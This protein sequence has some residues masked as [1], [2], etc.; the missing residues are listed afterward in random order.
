MLTG[1][2]SRATSVFKRPCGISSTSLS[3][4]MHR[5]VYFKRGF[6]KLVGPLTSTHQAREED[7]KRPSLDVVEKMA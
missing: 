4:L 2:G 1:F 3:T 5:F 6:N 7:G